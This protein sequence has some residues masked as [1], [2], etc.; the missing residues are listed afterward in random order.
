[1]KELRD[2]KI[3]LKPKLGL[4]RHN[5]FNWFAYNNSN[6]NKEDFRSKLKLKKLNLMRL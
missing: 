3:D 5:S 6:K 4:K 2:K 1:M